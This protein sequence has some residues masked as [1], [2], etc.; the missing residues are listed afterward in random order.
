[1]KPINYHMNTTKNP[2]ITKAKEKLATGILIQAR[3]DLRRFHDSRK[4]AEQ[5]LYLDAYSWVVSDSRRWPFSFLN[6]CKR[7]QLAPDELRHELL[8]QASLGTFSYWS[9][10]L[11]KGM[12]QL[13]LSLRPRRTQARQSHNSATARLV[14][15]LP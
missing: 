15:S 3:R 9:R 7:L 2:R 6:V 14:H 1:M 10:R 4:A 5:G 13:H 8:Q 12:R 11:G